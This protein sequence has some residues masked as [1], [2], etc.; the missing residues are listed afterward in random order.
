M[1]NIPP[2]EAR[3]LSLYDYE[4]MLWNWNDAQGSDDGGYPD[5]E[6][7]EA[8]IARINADPSLTGPTPAPE[9]V[10]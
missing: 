9:S 7:T 4:S 1:M 5:P 2:S 6:R 8:L 3:Q 10:N